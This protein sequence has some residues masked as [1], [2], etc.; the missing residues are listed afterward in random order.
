MVDG[1]TSKGGLLGPPFDVPDTAG[2]VMR[3]TP[4]GRD[5]PYIL[6]RDQRADPPDAR[7]TPRAK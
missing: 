7:G 1:G 5:G 4:D 2:A 3:G 6:A